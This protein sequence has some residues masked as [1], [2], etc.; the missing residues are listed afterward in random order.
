MSTRARPLRPLPA[1]L[2]G[3]VLLALFVAFASSPASHA[4]A[5]SAIGDSARA[6]DHIPNP[7]RCP[8]GVGSPTGGDVQW[9]FSDSGAPSN[10]PA[11]GTYY[12]H[13]R[14]T[15]TNGH[16]GGTVCI[17][18]SNLGAED[19]T[20]DLVL[21][22]AS[23]AHLSPDVTRMGLPGVQLELKGV[24]SASNDPDDCPAG[25]H[26]TV[27]LF[28]SYHATHRDSLELK[29]IGGCGDEHD[30]TFTGPQL[31]VLIARDG[32]QVN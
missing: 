15:W 12:T 1:L 20:R 6:A 17:D 28:A 24:L 14:G 10:V 4:S 7:G 30:H 9:A 25:T 5:A 8:I 21:K 27:T 16:A 19:G 22:I 13:G 31:H 3:G 26:G 29:F 11:L 18:E 23:S 2:A 32:A